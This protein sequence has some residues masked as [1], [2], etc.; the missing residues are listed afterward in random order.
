MIK[1]RIVV[2][3][4]A[5]LAIP[6]AAATGQTKLSPSPLFEGN[7]TTQTKGGAPQPV[8]ISVQTWDITNRHGAPQDV[9]LTG[10]YVAHL[11]SG[12]LASSIG[13]QTVERAPGDYWTVK[14]GE[15]MQVKARGELAI[16]ET[17]VAAKP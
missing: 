2:A 8:H 15:S 14:A 17:I 5:A 16:L 3:A 12:R 1:R 11:L 13:G 10:F 9:P 7:T 6:F 4:L